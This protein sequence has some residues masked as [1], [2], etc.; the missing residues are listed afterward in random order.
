MNI[1]N[2]LKFELRSEENNPKKAGQKASPVYMFGKYNRYLAYACHS[3]LE[4]DVYWLIA[5]TTLIDEYD[6]LPKPIFL[7]HTKDQCKKK[8]I[9]DI[10]RSDFRQEISNF[11]TQMQNSYKKCID[12][13]CIKNLFLQNIK[14][15]F[16]NQDEKIKMQ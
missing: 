2:H 12:E 4:N 8:H 14:A 1:K 13:E 3:R 15:Y 5:D 11:I 7:E 16:L 9:C 10:I 6:Q